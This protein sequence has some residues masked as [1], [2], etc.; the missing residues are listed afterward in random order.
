MFT[1]GNRIPVKT[2]IADTLDR[3]NEGNK[4]RRLYRRAR[5]LQITYIKFFLHAFSEN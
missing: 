4:I 2:R 3:E 1:S 5:I